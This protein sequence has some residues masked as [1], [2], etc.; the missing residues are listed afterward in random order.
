MA[1]ISQTIQREINPFDSTTFRPGNFWQEQQS[2]VL[3][4]E[5]I[6]Q[7]AI[8]A[9]KTVL[10]QVASDHRTRTLMLYG[11]SGSGKSHLLG[12]LKRQ[13][14]SKAFFCLHWSLAR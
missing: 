3:N 12:R 14:N 2:P 7:E 9:I 10:D 4:V 1:S 6:H 8:S 13:L 5:S 11:D